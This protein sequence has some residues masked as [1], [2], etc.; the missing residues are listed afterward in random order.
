M[1]NQNHKLIERIEINPRVLLGKPVIKGTR[2]SVEQIVRMLAGGMTPQEI[3]YELPHLTEADIRAA[4][5]YAAEILRDFRVYPR[6]FI[7]CI[8]I[9]R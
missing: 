7:H 6:E 2:I 9:P 8:K 4:V 1:Y 3:I 5:F